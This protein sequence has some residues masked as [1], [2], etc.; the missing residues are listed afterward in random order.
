[1]KRRL[2]ATLAALAAMA[3]MAARAAVTWYAVDPMSERRYM[4]DAEPVGGLKGEPVRIVA[5]VLN[6]DFTPVTDAALRAAVRSAKSG[7]EQGTGNRAQEMPLP[8]GL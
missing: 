8:R 4:P 7:R 3:T 6:P 5:R 1:M 2:G